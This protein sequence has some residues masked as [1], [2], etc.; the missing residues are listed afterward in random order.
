MRTIDAGDRAIMRKA[1]CGR[2][3]LLGVPVFLCLLAAFLAASA[4][5]AMSQ[6]GHS[7]DEQVFDY[8]PDADETTPKIATFSVS[9]E[10]DADMAVDRT[11]GIILYTKDRWKNWVA[12]SVYI[13]LLDIALL[14]IILSL[15]KNEEYYII[16]AYVLCGSSM[17]L[18]FWVFLCAALLF[19][20][21]AAAWVYIIPLSAVMAVL[22][23]VALAKIKGSDVSLS[24]LKESFQKLSATSSED[25]RLLSVEGS[26][27]DWPEKDFMK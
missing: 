21:H 4:G 27:G 11:G 7:A 26:P 1:A 8:N 9:V 19:K 3:L 24:E 12:R 13:L 25:R 10:Y 15:P 16:I 5:P 18:A 6:I 17:L 2:P 20:L 22:S 23:L 14:G